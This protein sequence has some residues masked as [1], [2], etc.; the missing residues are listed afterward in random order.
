MAVGFSYSSSNMCLAHAMCECSHF[1]GIE[2][3]NVL[4]PKPK[5]KTKTISPLQY[6]YIL[7]MEDSH[8]PGWENESH[9]RQNKLKR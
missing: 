4:T 2:A 7:G 5:S 1:M 9:I 8:R 6:N 3:W